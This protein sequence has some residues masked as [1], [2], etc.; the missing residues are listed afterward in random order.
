MSPPAGAVGRGDGFL[1]RIADRTDAAVLSNDSFQEFHG[2]YDW[3]FEKGRLIGGKPVSGVGWIFM[4]RTPVRGPRSRVAVRAAK[5]AARR[6]AAEPGPRS[7]KAA[8]AIAK[9]TADALAPDA[10]DAARP[11]R[12]GPPSDPV[13]DPLPRNVPSM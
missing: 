8:A 4:P 10:A 2:Q 7:R 12:D 6:P 1:L 3:L 9:A 5:Q 11:A 13:N